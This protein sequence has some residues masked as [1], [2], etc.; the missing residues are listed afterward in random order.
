[1][2]V[3]FNAITSIQNVIQIH[4]SVQ[5]FTLLRSLNVRH[6]E[7]VE[8]TGLSSMESRSLSMSSSPYKISSKSINRFKSSAHLRSLNARQIEMIEATGLNSM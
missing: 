5:K 8:D 4:Q 1:M 2:E 6:F 7:M 3:N